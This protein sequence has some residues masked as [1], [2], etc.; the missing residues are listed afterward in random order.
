MMV[1][2]LIHVNGFMY[3]NSLSFYVNRVHVDDNCQISYG[4]IVHLG[5]T[6]N[7]SRAVS[8]SP[9]FFLLPDP[10]LVSKNTHKSSHP[11]SHK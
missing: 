8:P 5:V 11:C 1:L 3:M 10:S 9:P 2:L 7:L 6:D 4:S